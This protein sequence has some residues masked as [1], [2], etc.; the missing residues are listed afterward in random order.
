MVYHGFIMVYHGLSWLIMGK[1]H[2]F[3]RKTTAIWAL[4]QP[5][6]EEDHPMDRN[7]L[8]KWIVSYKPR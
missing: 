1:Y 3:S 2:H 7:C 4:T 5:F 8:V 6:V